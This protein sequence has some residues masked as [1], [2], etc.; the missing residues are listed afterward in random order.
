METLQMRWLNFSTQVTMFMF[1]AQFLGTYW[2][3]TDIPAC[4]NA[5]NQHMSVSTTS[6]AVMAV[7]PIEVLEVQLPEPIDTIE[8][9]NPL[10][11]PYRDEVGY[12]RSTNRQTIP[13]IVVG[14]ATGP[15]RIWKPEISEWRSSSATL[16]WPLRS[17][18]L[19]KMLDLLSLSSGYQVSITVTPISHLPNM[20][21]FRAFCEITW[22]CCLHRRSNTEVLTSFTRELN[23]RQ[24]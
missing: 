20:P 1:G 16:P 18:E 15:T 12:T 8:N 3:I 13:I 23:S 17:L 24:L 6:Q 4:H 21:Y 11:Q 10:A 9:E 14:Y 5:D 19:S 2:A 7:Q 22:Q